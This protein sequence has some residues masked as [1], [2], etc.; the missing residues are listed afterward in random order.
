MPDATF[1]TES[2]WYF[3]EDESRLRD[4]A[5]AAGVSFEDYMISRAIAQSMID[6]P[7]VGRIR[8]SWGLQVDKP[9]Y[10]GQLFGI[11]D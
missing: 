2:L 11:T 7:F 10:H 5:A 6:Q 1:D 9:R 8:T 4:E 3:K